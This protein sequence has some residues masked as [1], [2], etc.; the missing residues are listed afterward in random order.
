MRAS[1]GP[2]LCRLPAGPEPP[3]NPKRWRGELFLF[4]FFYFF[5]SSCCFSGWA[6]AKQ[7]AKGKPAVHSWACRVLV[8]SAPLPI[9]R[10]AMGGERGCL[11]GH[12]G[13]TLLM[14]G[15][16][17]AVG[18]VLLTCRDLATLV[19]RERVTANPWEMVRCNSM[20]ER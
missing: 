15:T 17:D 14:V 7:R 18:S 3:I 5:S 10:V 1:S 12:V 11:R 8:L 4:F 6:F 2:A 9:C 19:A 13:V 16:P 20:V